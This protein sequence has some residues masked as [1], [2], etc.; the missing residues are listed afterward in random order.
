M[1]SKFSQNQHVVFETKDNQIIEGIIGGIRWYQSRHH[2]PSFFMVDYSVFPKSSE[3]G[4]CDDE[5][6]IPE[7]HVECLPRILRAV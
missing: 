1:I 2:R 3:G 6:W 5:I 4:E 7:C